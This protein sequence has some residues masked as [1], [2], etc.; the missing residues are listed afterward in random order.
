MWCFVLASLRVHA[1]FT[2]LIAALLALLIFIT[3]AMDNPF[4]GSFGLGPDAYELTYQQ[5]MKP[6]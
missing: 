1:L 3:A 2:A 4:R 5:L 6:Q